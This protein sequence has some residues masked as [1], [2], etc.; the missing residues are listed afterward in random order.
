MSR[1]LYSGSLPR[2]LRPGMVPD[3]NV[4]LS[5]TNSSLRCPA[6][7]KGSDGVQHK[8][9]RKPQCCCCS[10]RRCDHL[11]CQ[12][13][14]SRMGEFSRCCQRRTRRRLRSWECHSARAGLNRPRR[15]CTPPDSGNKY[16]NHA[17]ERHM[18]SRGAH[19]LIALVTTNRTMS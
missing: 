19:M 3:P 16:R 5:P 1:Q 11:F 15:P 17:S 8:E 14:T 9:Q 4:K 18:R 12:S 10:N 6:L 7:H 2:G 13:R